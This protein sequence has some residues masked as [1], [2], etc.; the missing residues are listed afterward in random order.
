MD[1]DEGNG[2]GVRERE[3]SCDRAERDEGSKR[4]KSRDKS[5]RK[6]VGEKKGEGDK[7]GE[8]RNLRMIE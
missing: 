4:S 3:K 7:V 2:R 8:G 1:R 6:M 5:I